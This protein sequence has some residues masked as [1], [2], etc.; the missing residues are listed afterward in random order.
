[1]WFFSYRVLFKE[2]NNFFFVTGFDL[3]T[4]EGFEKFVSDFEDIVGFQYLKGMHLNDSKGM[5]R[6]YQWLANLPV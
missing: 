4:K 3:S 6:K 1:M 5:F 2:L